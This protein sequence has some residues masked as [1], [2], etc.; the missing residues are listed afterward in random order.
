M[1]RREVCMLY[2]ESLGG[3]LEIIQLVTYYLYFSSKKCTSQDEEK[4]K[5]FCSVEDSFCKQHWL[6]LPNL[7]GWPKSC[8][9]A[10]SIPSHTW[11]FVSTTAQA[12]SCV[13]C[14]YQS[15]DS[16]A[17]L[18]NQTDFTWGIHWVVGLEPQQAATT[19]QTQICTSTTA[20]ATPEPDTVEVHI[21][22][23]SH[24][25]GKLL[26]VVRMFSGLGPDSMTKNKTDH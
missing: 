24:H 26:E 20:T 1:K 5:V 19:T 23:F 10:S 11:V 25:D 7:W 15:A 14:W 18:A 2:K 21:A 12:L 3:D 8:S 13:A 6:A 4:L 22:H 17:P 9:I 16:G